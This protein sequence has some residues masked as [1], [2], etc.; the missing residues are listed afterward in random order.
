MPRPLHL[1]ACALAAAFAAGCD[2]PSKGG[3]TTSAPSAAASAAL[4]A[5]P[6]PPKPK[7]MPD[8]LVDADGPY[9]G[10][11]RVAMGEADSAARLAKKM[12]DLPING[13]DVTIR[14]D[15]KAK[16]SHV[17]AVVEALGDA[18]APR[19]KIKT[20]GRNDLP[21]EL[22][23]TPESRITSAPGCSIV[24]TVMK[25]LSTAVWPIKGALAKKQRKGLAG[26][27]FSHTGEQ[28]EKELALCDSTNA[29]FQGDD[30]VGWELIFNLAGTL[31][32]SDKKKKL[33]TL[34]LLHEEPVAGRPV[35]LGRR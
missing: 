15:K 12:K 13:K 11:A 5:P 2:E 10:G 31:Q 14:V 6:E 16:A 27:D 26:P 32:V 17:S 35:T 3:S 30:G 28:L 4:A 29:F 33:D 20:D 18:G 25:D 7:T 23:V 21:Q 24:A 9:I 34:V 22:S 1:F 8:I 19:V